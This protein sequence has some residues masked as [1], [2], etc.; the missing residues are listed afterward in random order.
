M[1]PAG[2]SHSEIRGSKVVCASPRLIAA[3]RV[4]HRLRVPRHPPY[5]LSCLTE[6][7]CKFASLQ[8]FKFTSYNLSTFQLVNLPTSFR[9]R[10]MI[11]SSLIIIPVELTLTFVVA[12]YKLP[13]ASKTCTLAHLL[14]YYRTAP[15]PLEGNDTVDPSFNFTM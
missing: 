1:T 2:L 6:K 14:T 13:I 12:S 4:L 8:V 15:V 10:Q 5:A 11:R 9:P 7:I 3:Y